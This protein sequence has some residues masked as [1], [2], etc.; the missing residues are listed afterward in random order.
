[1]QIAAMLSAVSLMHLRTR[2]TAPKLVT[3]LGWSFWGAGAGAFGLGVL[4]V[5]G[6]FVSFGALIGLLIVF[7]VCARRQDI[8]IWD[9]LDR[10]APCFALLIAVARVGC[11]LGGC[12]YGSISQVSWAV[13]FP[14]G[15]I[16]FR[17]H[18]QEGWILRT[19]V[20]SLPVHPTQIYET[21]LGIGMLSLSLGADRVRERSGRRFALC[22]LTYG[23]G[24]FVI[25][26][27]RDIHTQVAWGPLS[28]AQWMS[29]LLAG[30]AL[31]IL[32]IRAATRMSVL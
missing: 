24:R 6:Y 17:H 29:A 8:P 25:E 32:P 10:L 15:S 12:D 1:M 26:Y 22:L 14:P 3:C 16:P 4:I 30:A 18:V 11:F 7:V 20:A 9:A 19:D 23:L 2:E 13:Q 28:S 5:P 31:I 21:L 27:S